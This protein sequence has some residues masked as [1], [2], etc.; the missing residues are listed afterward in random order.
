MLTA[1][2]ADDVVDLTGLME[3]VADPLM[4]QRSLRNVTI[5]VGVFLA[6][7]FVL[8]VVATLVFDWEAAWVVR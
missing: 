4:R 8:A 6:I 7:A 5:A 2:V 3:Q 1:A